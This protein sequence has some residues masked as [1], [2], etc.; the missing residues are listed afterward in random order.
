LGKLIFGD[1][2]LDVEDCVGGDVGEEITSPSPN[3][4]LSL[5][6]MEGNTNKKRSASPL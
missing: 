4:S 6:E 3:P 2:A 1:A 5:K